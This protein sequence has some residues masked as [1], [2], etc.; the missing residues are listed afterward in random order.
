[1]PRDM[2]M[3]RPRPRIDSIVLNNNIPIRLQ[4]LHIPTL[5][6]LRIDNRRLVPLARAFAKHIHIVPV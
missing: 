2:A 5:R 6:V 4:Q 3:K 1:M